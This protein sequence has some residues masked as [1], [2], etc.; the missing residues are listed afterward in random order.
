VTVSTYVPSKEEVAAFY[1][2]AI[3]MISKLVGV[4]VHVGYWASADDPSTVQ[5]ATDRLTDMM[6]ERLQAGQGGRVLDVGCGLGEPAIRLARNLGV[7]VVGIATS[8]KLVVEATARAQAAGVAGRV[9]FE[10]VDA[11]DLPYAEAEF[12]AVLAIESIVHMPDRAAVFGQLARVLRPGGRLVLTDCVETRE[13]TARERGIVEN[14]RRFSMNSPFLKLDAY[15]RALMDTG[16][17][18]VE[19]VDITAETAVHQVHMMAAL[20]RNAAEL[21]AL[22]GPDMLS[23]YKSVF[24]DC[25]SAGLPRYMLMSAERAER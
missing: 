20:D 9:V 25:L 18:P 16:L 6:G 3:P 19:F 22:Y 17:L 21:T 24:T 7:D 5:Q 4:N 14:Y 8:P 2:E 1:D 11:V 23:T 12:D 15:M 10:V 13:P